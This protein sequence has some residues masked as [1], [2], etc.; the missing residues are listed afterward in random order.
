MIRLLYGVLFITLII[1]NAC[2]K[3][4]IPS[5]PNC[6][7]DCLSGQES[8]ILGNNCRENWDCAFGMHTQSMVDTNRESGFRPGAN[9]VFRMV[10]ST[11][12]DP[13]IADDE[14]TQVLVFELDDSLTSVS[15]EGVELKQLNMYYRALCYCVDTDYKE[16][17]NGCLQGEKQADGSWYFQGHLIAEYSFGE[18]ELKFEARFGL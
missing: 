6:A 4:E 12:G 17:R 8:E 18:E 14:L 16:I 5:C 2:D 11:E 3:E 7:F 13:G 9:T 1:T 10:S 15:V